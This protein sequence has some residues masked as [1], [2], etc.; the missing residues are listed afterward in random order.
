MS[1]RSIVAG[2]T[3]FHLLKTQ[4][5][6]FIFRLRLARSVFSPFNC[7]LAHAVQRKH[8]KEDIGCFAPCCLIQIC[9]IRVQT[10]HTSCLSRTVFEWRYWYDNFN[11][12]IIHL[13][14][15]FFLTTTTRSLYVTSLPPHEPGRDDSIRVTTYLLRPSFR[16]FS[17]PSPPPCADIYTLQQ[18]VS[19]AFNVKDLKDPLSCA[20]ELA[21]KNMT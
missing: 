13:I 15:F 17:H 3:K 4:C 8:T 11:P 12:T 5:A 16:S 20:R 9:M 21:A 6:L 1:L 14:E 2:D 7:R 19:L 18:C 10:R